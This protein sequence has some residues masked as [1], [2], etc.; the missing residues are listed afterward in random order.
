MTKQS[1][2]ILLIALCTLLSACGRE[3]TTEQSLDNA[4][5]NMENGE[6]AA[7][8]IELKSAAQQAPDNLEVRRQLAYLHLRVGE[9]AAA[10]KEIRR[11]ME[12]GLPPN[13][14]AL[15]LVKSIF[16]QQDFE[17]LVEET[18]EFE[19]APDPAIQSE[20]LAYRG[21][22]LLQLQDYR[23][24]SA[25]VDVALKLQ[26]DSAPALVTKAAL[27][28]LG[29][30]QQKAL[31]S[32]QR[33][34][35]SDPESADAWAI[36]GDLRASAG[37]MAGAREAYTKAIENRGYVDIVYARRGMMAARLGDFAQTD[38]DVASLEAAGLGRVPYVAFLKGYSAYLQKDYG[39]ASIALGEAAAGAPDSAIMKL[40]LVASLIETGELE[41]AQLQANEFYARFPGSLD[42]A[43]LLA[44]ISVERDDLKAAQAAL[45]T[46]LEKTGADD[47][48]SLGMLGAM[49]LLEGNGELAAQYLEQALALDPGNERLES[50]LLQARIIRGDFI[51]RDSA[52]NDQVVPPERYGEVLLSAASALKQGQLQ[53]AMA[54]AQNVQRQYPERVEALN[55]MGA[56]YFAAGDWKS[57]RE[58]LQKVLEIDPLD[59]SAVKNLARIHLQM[60]EPEQALE[61]LSG[62]LEQY[63]QDAEGNGIL[64]R[65]IMTGASFEQGEQQLLALLERDPGNLE[66]KARVVRFYFDNERYERVIGLTEGL[67]DREIA[68]QP[69]LIELR[70]KAYVNT[71]QYD[72][73]MATWK[74]WLQVSPD[75]V[76]AHFYYAEALAN[77]GDAAA[78]LTAMQK[79]SSLNPDYLP[80]RLA[81][82]RMT[83][84]AGDIATARSALG[85]LQAELGRERGEV[86]YLQGSLDFQARDYAAA[87]SALRRSLEVEPSP[88]AVLLLAAVLGAQSQRAGEIPALLREWA[89]E[90]PADLRIQA[91]LAESQMV[92]GDAAAAIA[93]YQGMLELAP[94]SALTLN[95]L[96][97]LTRES[98]P[99][100]ALDYARRAHAAAPDDAV[101]LDTY[102]GVLDKSGNPD[103]ALEMLGRA[104]QIDPDNMRYKM[105]YADLL[106]RQGSAAEAARLWSEVLAGS[107]DPELVAEARRR[108]GR[109]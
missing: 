59:P 50:M 12:L 16:F 18:D 11:A 102:A 107:S 74:K 68:G 2:W 4:R 26:P 92:S 13:E 38:R 31:E 80:A 35:A 69:A 105:H 7:A 10:E 97:W 89:S 60:G 41:R 40:Y 24:A 28:A 90:Y 73:A 77:A 87:E 8:L 29:G 33:A 96:A 57:G 83:A 55:V 71:R 20:I 82:I 15:L 5:R 42:A 106:A 78:A 23:L 103:L 65:I 22:A 62:Y 58:T 45:L 108:L 30:N 47:P 100:A 14:S 75:S 109:T 3:V 85:K 95:N 72:Y 94:Q 61:L 81:V 27:D 104:I 53:A 39:A 84:Q 37:D 46:S 6:L 88:E 67:G 32:V 36:T 99:A 64:A 21:R 76:L 48:V 49:A 70:G 98:D 54:I 66:V 101:V 63:P 34:L 56:V 44:S 43:R 25:T 1:L 91:S 51:A 79:A 17:R 86:L 19:G 52:G 93:T 9:G